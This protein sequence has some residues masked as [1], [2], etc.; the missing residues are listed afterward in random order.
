MVI[1]LEI[2]D[3]G[4]FKFD[5]NEIKLFDLEKKVRQDG[6]KIIG[7]I[8]D[9]KILDLHTIVNANLK[10][11]IVFFDDTAESFEIV[12]HTVAHILAQAV[13]RLYPHVKFSVGPVIENGF[14]YD[15]DFG[16]ITISTNNLEEIENE[17]HK[18]IEENHRITK[19]ITTRD[20]IISL[21][22]EKSEKYKL[23]VVEN[24]I[25]VDDEISIYRQGEFW[26]LCRGP[27][28]PST[29]YIKKKSFKLTKL[30]GIY[31]QNDSNNKMLQRITGTAWTNKDGLSKYLLRLEEAGKRDH[32]KLGTE[33][34]LF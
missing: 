9:N 31:W 22:K 30:S 13:M 14:F 4:V 11:K 8:H 24:N 26:D 33:L 20:E 1:E 25:K 27:H 34:G 17:M 32:R 6:K 12:R 3:H 28:L 15:F 2:L 7:F 21:L 18:I 5:E 23:H 16:D 10:L 19:E 29:G